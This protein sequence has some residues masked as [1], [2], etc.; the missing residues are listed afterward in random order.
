MYVLYTIMQYTYNVMSFCY[1]TLPVTDSF[2]LAASIQRTQITIHAWSNF[3]LYYS[4][5]E[6]KV[7]PI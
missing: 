5:H 6:W 4:M 2:T 1:F 7:L 3:G